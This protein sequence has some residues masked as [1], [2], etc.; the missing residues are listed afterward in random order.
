MDEGAASGVFL[1]TRE[2]LILLGYLALQNPSV[3]SEIVQTTPSAGASEEDQ[4]TMWLLTNLPYRYYLDGSEEQQQLFPTLLAICHG[5]DTNT[6]FLNSH[7]G[8]KSLG[9]FLQAV[10]AA[11]ID[12]S[13]NRWIVVSTRFPREY[14]ETA[15]EGLMSA[16]TMVHDERRFT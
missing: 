4:S 12:G 14:W 16:T 11:S 6:E 8:K 5:N 15:Q 2:L 3:Q 1:C 13:G 7:M 9:K 10:G